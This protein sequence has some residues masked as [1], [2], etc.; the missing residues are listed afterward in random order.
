MPAL[1]PN[2]KTRLREIR[3][4][5]GLSIR[6]VADAT[7]IPYSVLQ[8][9]EAGQ[10]RPSIARARIIF[11]YYDQEVDL[12]DIHDPLFDFEVGGAE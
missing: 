11:A 7:K 9:I 12:G 10:R 8:R 1:M 4:A 3:V 6:Q 2:T 5:R